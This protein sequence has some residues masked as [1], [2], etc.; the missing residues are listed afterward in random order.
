MPHL[1]FEWCCRACP[2]ALWESSGPDLRK[3]ERILAVFRK[4]QQYFARAEY[5]GEG[6]GYSAIFRAI[7]TG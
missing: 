3:V 7:A 1:M 6:P 4:I 5:S 2:A